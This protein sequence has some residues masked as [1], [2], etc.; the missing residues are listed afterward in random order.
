MVSAFIILS[1]FLYTA[2][3]VSLNGQVV[4]HQR[5]IAQIDRSILQR[6]IRD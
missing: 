6:V 4:I 5:D 1:P 3:V 2:L